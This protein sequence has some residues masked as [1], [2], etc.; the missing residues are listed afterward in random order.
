MQNT[1]IFVSSLRGHA[2][3]LRDKVCQWLLRFSPP[4]KL[5]RYNWNIV[6]SGVKHHKPNQNQPLVLWYHFINQILNFQES[7]KCIRKS[8]LRWYSCCLTARRVSHVEQELW[9]LTEHLNSPPL[10]SG[11][12]VTRSFVFCAMFCRSV[13]VLLSFKAFSFR[14][15]FVCPSLTY[16]SWLP[17]WYRQIFLNKISYIVPHL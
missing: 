6:E 8:N 15:W 5:S 9:T 11:V 13:F 17:L 1:W 3:V 7:G 12:R 16:G 14:H 10:F 2:L 4:I